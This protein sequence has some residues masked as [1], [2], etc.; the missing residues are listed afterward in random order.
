MANEPTDNKVP[1]ERGEQTD[2]EFAD[3]VVGFRA[4][5]AGE[6]NDDTKLLAWQ[7]G[8]ADSQE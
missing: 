7:R 6:P 8:W 2:E 5:V 3:Y 4:G 1:C